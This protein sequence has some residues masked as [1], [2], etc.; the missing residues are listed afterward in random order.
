VPIVAA[1]PIEPVGFH[2]GEFD[3]QI[4]FPAPF[5]RDPAPTP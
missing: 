4:T 3:E 1:A 5:P 2:D